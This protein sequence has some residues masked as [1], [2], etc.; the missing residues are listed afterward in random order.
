MAEDETRKMKQNAGG[1]S[2]A[3][4]DT[5]IRHS[6]ISLADLNSCAMSMLQCMYLARY[7]FI[8]KAACLS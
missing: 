2:Q 5:E 7:L 1:G 4:Y 3:R 6:E 8:A